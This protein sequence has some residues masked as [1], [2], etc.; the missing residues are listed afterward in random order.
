MW[1]EK[2]VR[3]SATQ[4]MMHFPTISEA[5]KPQNNYPKSPGEKLRHQQSTWPGESCG[6]RRL[7]RVGWDDQVLLIQNGVRVSRF[8]STTS[9]KC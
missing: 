1:L 9:H 4:A 8:V 7:A 2:R 6:N 3:S 5:N